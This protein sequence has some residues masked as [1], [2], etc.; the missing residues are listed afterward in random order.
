MGEMN[1]FQASEADF[2]E[3]FPPDAVKEGSSGRDRRPGPPGASPQEEA[4]DEAQLAF[5]NGGGPMGGSEA[6]LHPPSKALRDGVL[7][8]SVSA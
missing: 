5:V 1:N 8:W 3:P 6:R 2:H 7:T 4:R